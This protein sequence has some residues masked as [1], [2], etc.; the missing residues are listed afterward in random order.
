MRCFFIKDGHVTGVHFLDKDTD[1]GLLAQAQKAFFTRVG[2]S[3][4]DGFEIWEGARF[5]ARFPEDLK[6]PVTH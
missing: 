6:S 5:V 4:L 1:V 3:S 2:H